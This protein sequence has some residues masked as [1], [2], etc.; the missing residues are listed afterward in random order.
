MEGNKKFL[1]LTFAI[2]CII[3]LVGMLPITKYSYESISGVFCK[4]DE[5]VDNMVDILTDNKVFYSIK[6]K[7]ITFNYEDYRDILSVYK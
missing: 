4:S 7:V 3:F 1:K 5:E 2:V 6:N